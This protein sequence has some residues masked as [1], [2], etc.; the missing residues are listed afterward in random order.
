MRKMRS[1]FGIILLTAI[2]LMSST[3]ALATVWSSVK[4]TES[5]TT[6]VYR[7]STATSVT[8]SSS[9]DHVCSGD[10]GIDIVWASD[11][12]GLSNAFVQDT[13]RLAHFKLYE[14][15]DYSSALVHEY[16]CHFAVVNGVYR[17]AMISVASS[18]PYYQVIEYDGTVELWNKFMVEHINGDNSNAV[19]A[20]IMAFKYWTN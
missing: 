6:D 9:L 10:I 2:V 11:L 1:I 7:S 5:G 3:R 18:A 12:V 4:Y 16:N 15:D 19:F 14:T 8:Y 20:K 13:S 17:P